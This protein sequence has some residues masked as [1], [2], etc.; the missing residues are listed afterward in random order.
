VRGVIGVVAA[1]AVGLSVPAGAAAD[2]LGSHARA[3]RAVAAAADGFPLALS[4]SVPLPSDAGATYD[5]PAG[6]TT[7]GLAPDIL[8]TT[9]WSDA[10]GLMTFAVAIPNVPVLRD[11]DFYAL[12]LDVDGD[13]ATGNPG[14]GGADYAI[15]I[16]G[17]T[18]TAGLARWHAGAWD[19][20]TPQAS[21]AAAWSSGPAIRIDRAELGGT[22]AL[23]FWQGASWTDTA[24]RSTS[25]YA[26]DTGTWEYVLPGLEQL[27]PPPPD[28]AAPA[29]RALRTTGR[30]G[31]F[32]AIRYR[33]SDD[34]GSTRERIRVFRAS[35]RLLWTYR[36]ELAPSEAG[37]VYWVPWQAP[38]GVGTRLRFCVRAWDETGNASR[39]SCAPL[40]LRR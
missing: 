22:A 27:P 4:D 36:T 19:F 25:D 14:A 24:G 29:V 18:R 35:G 16:H 31:G 30:T 20:P 23:R 34:S 40:R 32:V 8:R 7:S 17:S 38:R 21:L 5:D 10:A 28:R 13:S 9:V 11:R 6:D 33:L 39:P 12:F 26:P 15:A 2:R 1:L 37:R 3:A